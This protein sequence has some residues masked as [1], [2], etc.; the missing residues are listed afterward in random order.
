MSTELDGYFQLLDRLYVEALELETGVLPWL[1]TKCSEMDSDVLGALR[2]R[3]ALLTANDR[4]RVEGYLELGVFALASD[5]T[6]RAALLLTFDLEERVAAARFARQCER[7][8]ASQPLF[9]ELPRLLSVARKDELIPITAI[10]EIRADGVVAIQDVFARLS[11]FVP[12]ASIDFLRAEHPRAPLF[13]RLD[14]YF[15]A[16]DEPPTV[17]MEAI[18]VPPNPNWWRELAI[19]VGTREGGVYALHGTERAVDDHEAFWDYHVRRV[20][21]LEASATR[22]EEHMLA[23]MLEELQVGRGDELFGRCVHLDTHDVQGHT[24]ETA[25]LAHLD[26][27]IQMYDGCASQARL[28]QYLRNGRVQD[29]SWRTHLLRTEGVLLKDLVPVC[30]RFFLSLRLTREMILSEFV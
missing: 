29:A 14:P 23:M 18:Q 10:H 19:R 22:R 3:E 8:S 21:R 25:R 26:L 13:V 2:I 1:E 7:Y 6:R 30:E 9:R 20:R 28:K 15:V 11:P 4:N 5:E 16:R 27:A 12:V 24:P 17:L